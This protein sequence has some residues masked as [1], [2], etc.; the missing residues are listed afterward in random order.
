MRR[1]NPLFLPL[2]LR[3]PRIPEPATDVFDK[4]PLTATRGERLLTHAEALVTML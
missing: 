1:D 4:E 2:T 3:R